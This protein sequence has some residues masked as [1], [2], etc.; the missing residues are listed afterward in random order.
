MHSAWCLMPCALA[1]FT[2]RYCC[3]WLP[4]SQ[5]KRYLEC[6]GSMNERQGNYPS[7]T[8]HSLVVAQPCNQFAELSS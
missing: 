1:W 6:C 5:V 4:L 7:E 3:S 8:A 2:I